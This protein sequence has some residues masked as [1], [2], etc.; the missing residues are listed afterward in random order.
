MDI[1]WNKHLLLYLWSD[2]SEYT[3]NY[4]DNT[5]A[6]IEMFT[7]NF[8]RLALLY[9]WICKNSYLLQVVHM[10]CLE[11]IISFPTL[12]WFYVFRNWFFAFMFL[13]SD[14]K[15]SRI[16][17]KKYKKGVNMLL[18]TTSLFLWYLF[19][20]LWLNQSK[21]R[22]DQMQFPIS[23]SIFGLHQTYAISQDSFE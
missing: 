18:L 6:S 12:M 23:F 13:S 7:K 8:I 19:S 10:K 22:F 1:I 9:I 20:I 17:N 15:N 3:R 5:Q 16:L 21:R 2:F 14:M 11:F 4:S